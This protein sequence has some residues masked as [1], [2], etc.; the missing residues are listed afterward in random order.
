VVV[1]RWVVSDTCGPRHS[2]LSQPFLAEVTVDELRRKLFKVLWSLY[3]ERC[4]CG[5]CIALQ[6]EV[7]MI[8]V[9]DGCAV[10]R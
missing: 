5:L 3:R 7:T 10:P 4:V 8:I 6:W 2:I 1:G 9:V